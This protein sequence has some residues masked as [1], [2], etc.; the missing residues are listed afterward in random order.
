MKNVIKLFTDGSCYP[1]S[2]LGFGSYL[3]VYD[4]D[5]P[6]D[7]LKEDIKT[8]KFA[9]TSS[10]KLEVQTLLWALEDLTFE[11]NELIIYTDCQNII[12]LDDR[13]AG[14]ENK[15]YLTSKGKLINNHDLY[16]KFYSL[17]D[18]F[19]FKLVKVKGHKKN[20]LKNDIDK[21]FNL[22][23]KASRVAL[24]ENI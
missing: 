22:V 12:G 20:S 5:K 3:L 13:R 9:D 14:F 6:L 17:K 7:L 10:T 2:K 11:V 16:K 4:E 1:Q 23:D 15:N 24:R 18:K 21:V 19:D 8:K